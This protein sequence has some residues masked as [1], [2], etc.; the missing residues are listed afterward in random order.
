MVTVASF[1]LSSMAA[2][3]PTMLDRPTTTARLPLMGMLQLEVGVPVGVVQVGV[4]S[5]C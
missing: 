5:G 2:G 1:L 3:M 4:S